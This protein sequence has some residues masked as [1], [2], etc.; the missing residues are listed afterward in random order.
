MHLP[1]KQGVARSNRVGDG[2][3]PHK[4]STLKA[5]AVFFS[6]KINTTGRLCCA[7]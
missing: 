5:F 2:Q 1:P 6:Q 7:L 3:A 4:A